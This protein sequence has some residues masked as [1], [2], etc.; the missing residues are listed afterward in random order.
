MILQA[1]SWI[2]AKW[3][4]AQ[5]CVGYRAKEGG[6]STAGLGVGERKSG[7]AGTNGMDEQRTRCEAGSSHFVGCLR[8]LRSMFC[9]LSPS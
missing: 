3:Q 5:R 6:V 9:H 1:W 8:V 4:G 7:M 2:G